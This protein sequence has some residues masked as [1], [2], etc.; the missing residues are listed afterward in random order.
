MITP[1]Y[2]SDFNQRRPIF[3]PAWIFEESQLIAIGNDSFSRPM[4]SVPRA[5]LTRLKRH[6]M[7]E[8]DIAIVEII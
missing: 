8:H 6:E 1:A 7:F 5:E 3:M 4:Y 2:A